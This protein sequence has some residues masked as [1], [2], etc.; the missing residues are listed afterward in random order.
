MIVYTAKIISKP[1]SCVFDFG[2]VRSQITVVRIKVKLEE[3]SDFC[4]VF[5]MVALK[6]PPLHLFGVFIVLKSR[7]HLV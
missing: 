6:A 3:L 7:W 2:S 5:I 4:A 1:A